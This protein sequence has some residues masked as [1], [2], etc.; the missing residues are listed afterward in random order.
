MA[1]KKGQEK[2]LLLMKRSNR[3]V[4]ENEAESEILLILQAKPQAWNILRCVWPWRPHIC[5]QAIFRA[6]GSLWPLPLSKIQTR[7]KSW[8]SWT[9]A[10]SWPGRSKKADFA[11]AFVWPCWQ[12]TKTRTTLQ[13]Y[14][15]TFLLDWFQILGLIFNLFWPFLAFLAF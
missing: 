3:E 8:H 15:T 9:S 11:P 10:A 7:A 14:K 13:A 1:R 2:R 4:D 6:I 5:L 12:L